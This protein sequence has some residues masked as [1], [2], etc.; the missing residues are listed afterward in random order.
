MWWPHT[1]SMTPLNNMWGHT[2]TFKCYLYSFKNHPYFDQYFL[3]N[4]Q[5]FYKL[6]VFFSVFLKFWSGVSAQGSILGPLLFLIYIN[7]LC[8]VSSSLY[9]VIFADYS[10]LLISGPSLPDLFERL[11]TEIEK[12]TEWF[13][14]NKLSVN[15][16]KTHYMIFCANK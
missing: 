16:S 6:S 3:K 14:A 5:Y 7:N 4:Y 9:F 13:R 10:N 2:G 8:F 11:N 12:A 15:L 1:T